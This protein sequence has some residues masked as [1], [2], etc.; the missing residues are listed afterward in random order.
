[1]ADNVY[2]EDDDLLVLEIDVDRLSSKLQY[3]HV[4]GWSEPFPHI[5]GPLNIDAVVGT[6]NLTRDSD[7]R[8]SFLMLP[9]K[10]S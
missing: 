1:M 7:G 3:D 2:R 5:Y 10:S 9:D 8:V 4:S 6:H